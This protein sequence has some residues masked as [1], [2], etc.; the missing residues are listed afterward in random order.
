MQVIPIQL[1]ADGMVVAKDIC[2]GSRVLC[3]KGVKLTEPLIHRLKKMGI[4]SI[5]VEGHPV[6]LDGEESLDDM[7]EALEKRFRRVSGDP[8]MMK[9]KDLFC[10]RILRSMGEESGR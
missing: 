6:K 4:E 1:S 9:I 10:Q 5:A 7:L 3:G 8:L 2:D